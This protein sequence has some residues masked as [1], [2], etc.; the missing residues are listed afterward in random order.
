MRESICKD[1]EDDIEAEKP[2]LLKL[3]SIPINY[4]G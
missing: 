1:D 4:F 3:F 2:A